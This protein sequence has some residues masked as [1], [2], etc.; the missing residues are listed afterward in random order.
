MKSSQCCGLC[1]VHEESWAISHAAKILLPLLS[2]IQVD[3]LQ[4]FNRN[5]HNLDIPHLSNIS[6]GG[7]V[8]I[9]AV[10]KCHN[11]SHSTSQNK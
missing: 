1:V 2:T 6:E 7:S 10:N 3:Q 4:P 11:L 9:H 5:C 8:V